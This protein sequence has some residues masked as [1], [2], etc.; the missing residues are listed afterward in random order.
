MTLIFRLQSDE[1][2][3]RQVLPFAS[4]LAGIEKLEQLGIENDKLL[5]NKSP[6]QIQRGLD[7]LS[8]DS[9]PKILLNTER[10][11]ELGRVALYLEEEHSTLRFWSIY[12]STTTWYY[13]EQ[14]VAKNFF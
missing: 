10:L 8:Q 2:D 4:G 5:V 6:H 7:L 9:S 1:V 11:G 12:T 3:G 14:E 13:P